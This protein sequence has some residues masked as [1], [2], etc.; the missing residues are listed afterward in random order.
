MSSYSRLSNDY[1][2]HV[3]CRYLAP[4]QLHVTLILVSLAQSIHPQTPP[5]VLVPIVRKLSDAFVH[6]GVGPEVIAAGLNTV[7]EI[8][9]RQPLVME[10]QNDLL[11]DLVS[12]RK[13]KD[14]GVC[15]AARGIL[16]LYR[17]VNPELLR[18][19]E[20]GKTATMAAIAGK[21]L[22]AAAQFGHDPDEVRGIQGLNLLAK[23]F[24]EHGEEEGDEDKGWEGWD[25]EDA[26]DSDSDD[27]GGWIDV[28]SDEDGGID[29]PDSDDDKDGDE[30]G[31]KLSTKERAAQW[32]AK[33]KEKRA[34]AKAGASVE[35]EEDEESAKAKR[36]EAKKEAERLAEQVKA[37]EE[38]M[39]HIATTRVSS[40]HSTLHHTSTDFPPPRR[41]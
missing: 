17:E 1:C 35:D 7:R 38:A 19:R 2:L 30:D 14:K 22:T 37:E 11:E 40:V 36:E 4:H 26:S 41:F 27:S 10:G 16:A 6:P 21:P 28:S 34:R 23:H 8:C 5:D 3:S 15:A 33:R 13:S 9:S 29:I 20:R 12:Y 32:K 31:P 18:K 39:N 24:E 25:V